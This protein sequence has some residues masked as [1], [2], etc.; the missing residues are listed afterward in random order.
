MH[1]IDNIQRKSKIVTNFLVGQ[2]IF[3]L[4][5]KTGEI[6]ILVYLGFNSKTPLPTKTKLKYL[7]F[8]EQF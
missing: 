4:Q 5:I 1:L 7:S 3:G 8:M 2:V 6:L